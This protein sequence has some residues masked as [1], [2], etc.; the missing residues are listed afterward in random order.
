MENKLLLRDESGPFGSPYV[1][2]SRA[3]VTEKPPAACR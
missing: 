1:D 3:A 2:S